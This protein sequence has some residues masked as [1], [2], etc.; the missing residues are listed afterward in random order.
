MNNKEVQQVKVKVLNV[1]F[2]ITLGFDEQPEPELLCESLLETFRQISMGCLQKEPILK[3]L[4]ETKNNGI[5][6]YCFNG[7]I[8]EEGVL[9]VALYVPKDDSKKSPLILQPQGNILGLNRE[10]RRKLKR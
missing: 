8:S 9:D 6:N 2:Q 1:D 4:E 3:A 10:Q 7:E 5:Y